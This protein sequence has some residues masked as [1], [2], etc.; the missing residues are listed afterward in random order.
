MSEKDKYI[1]EKELK[2]ESNEDKNINHVVNVIACL[3]I[4]DN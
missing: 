1:S 2:L 3:I 4:L